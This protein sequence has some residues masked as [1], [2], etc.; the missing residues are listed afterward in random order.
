MSRFTI[1]EYNR[2]NRN[3][4]VEELEAKEYISCIFIS[5]PLIDNFTINEK[6]FINTKRRL[7][8]DISMIV[9]NEDKMLWYVGYVENIMNEI[10]RKFLENYVYIIVDRR[11]TKTVIDLFWYRI[12]NE[13]EQNT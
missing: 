1:F 9:S 8:I 6:D 11:Y 2:Q 12:E 13:N 7:F 10:L 4:I 3:L 5:I